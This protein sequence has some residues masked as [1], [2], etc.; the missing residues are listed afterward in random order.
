MVSELSRKE[1][2]DRLMMSTMG[3]GEWSG[4]SLSCVYHLFQVIGGGFAHLK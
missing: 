3:E 4:R 2:C 1:C